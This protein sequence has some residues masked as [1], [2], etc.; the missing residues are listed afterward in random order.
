M[1]LWERVRFSRQA[2]F[3]EMHGDSIK[4]FFSNSPSFFHIYLSLFTRIGPLGVWS[5][6]I[7]ESLFIVSVLII[8]EI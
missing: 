8:T 1:T 5:M 3:R 7:N 6:Y 2:N 4:L